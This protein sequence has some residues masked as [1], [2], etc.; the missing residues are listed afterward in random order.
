MMKIWF[1]PN[2]CWQNFRN[3]IGN[4]KKMKILNFKFYINFLNYKKIIIKNHGDT[5]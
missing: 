1:C 3:A 5:Y 4:I 2:C